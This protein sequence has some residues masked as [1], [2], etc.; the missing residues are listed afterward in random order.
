MKSVS[1]TSTYTTVN[2]GAMDTAVAALSLIE[3]GDKKFRTR[4][5][6]GESERCR[7]DKA[8][9]KESEKEKMNA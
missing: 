6:T 4:G 8:G 7:A 3:E 2:A 5:D 9:R 1:S